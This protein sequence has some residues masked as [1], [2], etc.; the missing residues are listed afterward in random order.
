[1]KT[2]TIE[3]VQ[4]QV[5]AMIAEAKAKGEA[6][7]AAARA[8]EGT[9]KRIAELEQT[10]ATAQAELRTLKASLPR[11]SG[12]VNRVAGRSQD[13]K[14]QGV[15]PLVRDLMLQGLGNKEVLEKVHEYYGN[16]WTTK[17]CISWYRNDFRQK[18]GLS[19]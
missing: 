9:Y 19:V 16:D 4:A 3:D 15:R 14:N 13:Q 8:A 17:T 10:I 18:E 6:L 12:E 7:I 2:Q 1:M 5:E 11:T